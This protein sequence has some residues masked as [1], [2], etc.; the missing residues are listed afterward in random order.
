MTAL[1]S[2]LWWIARGCAPVPVPY[3]TKAPILDGWQQLRVTA[4]MAPQYFNG[5]LQNVGIILGID[6]I[7]DIDLDSSAAVSIGPQF[8]PETGIVWGRTSKPASHWLYKT[9]TPATK[10]FRD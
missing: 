8:L 5:A 6:G 7:V 10:Q 4:D 1:E 9:E 2:A 3:K